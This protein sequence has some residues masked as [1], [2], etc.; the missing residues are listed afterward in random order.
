MRVPG[1][2]LVSRTIICGAPRCAKTTLALELAEKQDRAVYHTDDLI[3]DLSWSEASQFVADVWLRDGS[4]IIEG[5]AMSRALRKWLRAHP[6]GK[7]C[8]AIL[9]LTSP[10]VA[11]TPGQQT[12]AK[13]EETVWRQIEPELRARGVSIDY[14]DIVIE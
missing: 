2:V 3:G 13:G 14:P 6:E 12:L 9:R 10:L 7:P 5:V 1:R 4:W 8:D 11:L